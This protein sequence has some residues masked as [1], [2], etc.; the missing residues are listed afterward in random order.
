[1]KKQN[2]RTITGAFL[3][4]ICLF[5]GS[6]AVAGSVT[7]AGT[8]G[9][10]STY[11]VVPAEYEGKEGQFVA[12]A[13]SSNQ[14]TIS[15]GQ[16]YISGEF[17]Y[18]KVTQKSYSGVTIQ[19]TPPGMSTL[20]TSSYHF[21]SLPKGSYSVTLRQQETTSTTSYSLYKNYWADTEEET[22]SDMLY[23]VKN[24]TLPAESGITSRPTSGGGGTDYQYITSGLSIASAYIVVYGVDDG[25]GT[26]TPTPT[27]D[28]GGSS[29]S[30]ENN[31]T[32]NVT[33]P[34]TDDGVY[35]LINSLFSYVS[36]MQNIL[37]ASDD[38]IRSELA[39]YITELQ[40]AYQQ[41][42]SQLAITIQNQINAL[43]S[44]LSTDIA[45]LRS[46]LENE[47]ATL[48]NQIS[49][50]QTQQNALLSEFYSL[51]ADLLTAIQN[52][53]SDIGKLSE[54]LKEKY[55]AF[56]NANTT[57]RADL[58]KEIAD[59]DNAYKEADAALIADYSSKLSALQTL[60]QQADS[61]LADNIRNLQSAYQTADLQLKENL[62]L[63]L[64][65]LRNQMND[66]DKQIMQE[67]AALEMAMNNAD[68]TLKADYTN[69]IA[70]L[71]QRLSTEAAALRTEMSN[72]QKSYQTEIAYLKEN[73]EL[74]IKSLKDQTQSVTDDLHTQINA[75]NK[76][77]SKQIADLNT[78]HD[79]ELAALAAK[80]E[81]TDA[82]LKAAMEAYVIALQQQMTNAD[83]LLK[84]D[85]QG[86]LDNLS[87]AFNERLKVVISEYEQRINAVKKSI[88][89]LESDTKTKL[90]TQKALLEQE[91]A[92]KISALQKEY[93]ELIAKSDNP[94]KLEAE[95]ASKISE[96][97]LN[98]RKQI[99]EIEKSLAGLSEKTA[100][101]LLA[102]LAELQSKKEMAEAALKSTDYNEKLSL[103]VLGNKDNAGE[104][105]SE[106]EAKL[107]KLERELAALKE[108]GELSIEDVI[109]KIKA[110][111]TA[112]AAELE[113]LKIALKLYCDSVKDD[114]NARIS[115]L[116]NTISA[117]QNALQQ[118]MQTLENR[119]TYSLMTDEELENLEKSK[120]ELVNSLANQIA[121]LELAIKNA[122]A[123]GQDT[124]AL[125][126]K[127]AS[128]TLEY[129]N[130]QSDLENV[131]YVRELRSNSELALHR[132]WIKELQELT[133]SL[134]ITVK[135][136][137]D[138]IKEQK[139]EIEGLKTIIANLEKALQTEIKNLEETLKKY[140]DDNVT[141]LNAAAE[142]MKAQL[143]TLR[144]NIVTLATSAYSG[145]SSSSTGNNN[146]YNY[147]G[148]NKETL[149]DDR[150]L[151]TSK[152]TA[153]DF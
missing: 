65:N 37:S 118:R 45:T 134:Q 21:D 56:V 121:G 81:K 64:A 91:C 106:L 146:N 90:I 4:G 16:P 27:P 23:Y 67:I 71:E 32:V 126:S 150:D 149:E 60:M 84:A 82:E 39:R 19:I 87:G 92:N 78:K 120:Q 148:T 86:Q 20:T 80:S 140:V 38:A 153:L 142:D 75:L 53:S 96:T 66:A 57:L 42:D 123:E 95:L 1:M 76:D 133:V 33:T 111:D 136:Q 124:S 104:A 122:K 49:G 129:A 25:S 115:S 113:N 28:T 112:N 47:I 30:G 44:A 114:L 102:E 132:K 69:K 131:K 77:F 40:N 117:L 83:D 107:A 3:T 143:E 93:A 151:R 34:G 68:D 62:E 63:Q 41:A 141:D 50:L 55:D 89:D 139:G 36:E 46:S 29:A 26:G 101:E 51:K 108:L 144:D 48:R 52:N 97:N 127:L 9:T 5:Y 138:T 13:T 88:N 14:T 54:E 94:E 99:L 119:L 74:Q 85:L 2:L 12:T 98:Y 135:Q 137:G 6:N 11:I 73:L 110:G 58:Q 128:L 147:S 18:V 10:N 24:G 152:D 72:L 8:T 22:F 145:Y 125:E 70:A 43:S 15:Y 105:H 103:I 109:A 79:A 100:A 31:I 17:A 35:T 59:L 116:E 7:L 130:A 61:S